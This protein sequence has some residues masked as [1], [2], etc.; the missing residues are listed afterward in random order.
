MKSIDLRCPIFSQDASS[1]MCKV[2]D[3][4]TLTSFHGPETVIGPWR[5]S[6]RSLQ[7]SVDAAGSPILLGARVVAH[8]AQRFD[9]KVVRNSLRAAGGLLHIESSWHVEQRELIARARIA[10]NVPPPLSWVAER[11]VAAKARVQMTAFAK[12]VLTTA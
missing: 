5:G 8:V 6:E 12:T 7:F 3:P 11:Y 10:V 4:E 9:G 2:L 1:I